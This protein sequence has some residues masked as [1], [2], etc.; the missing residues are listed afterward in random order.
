MKVLGGPA[1]QLLG[2]RVARQIGCELAITE[3]KQF[4]DGEQYLRV[5]EELDGDTLVVQST[6]TND[7]IIYL[8][9]LI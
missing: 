9:Q 4:P 8:L 7:D 5:V 6:T 2:A 3:F 1:S